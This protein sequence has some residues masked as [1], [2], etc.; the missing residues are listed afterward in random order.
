VAL[1]ESGVVNLPFE[2]NM[3]DLQEY[4]DVTPRLP[5]HLPWAAL[6]APGIV[7]QKENYL[8]KTYAFRGFDLA[9][10][11]S[12]EL[13]SNAARLNNVLIRLG[14]GWS[15]FVEAQRFEHSQY[16]D[17]KWSNPVGWIIDQERRRSYEQ[18]G[19]HFDS[20]YFI[21]FAYKLPSQ[22]SKKIEAIFYDDP[23]RNANADYEDNFKDLKKFADTI[24][25]IVDIMK[26]VF[27]EIE[28]LDDDQTLSYLHSSISTN[29]HPV[30]SPEIPMYLD[31]L[32][33]DQALTT[34]DIVML[35]DYF[36]PTCTIN[37]FPTHSFPGI[38][39]DL[40]HMNIEYRWMT[41]W[42]CLSKGDAENIMRKIQRNWWKKRKSLITLLKEEATKEES[43]LM[44]NDAVNKATDADAALQISGTNKIGF[45][46]MTS[47]ISTWSRS[48]DAAKRNMNLLRQVVSSNGFAVKNET[49]NSAQAWFGSLPGNVRPNPRRYLIK[50]M[51]LAHILPVSSIWAGNYK[52]EFLND[53]SGVDAPH[54]ICSTTGDTPFYLNLNDKDVGNTMI[55]G[56][57]GSGKSTLLCMLELQWLKYPGAQVI[58]FDKDRSARSAT[59]AVGGNFYE[60]G[61]E[62]MPMAFQPLSDIDDK[63]ERIWAAQLILDMLAVQNVQESPSIKKEID[64][65][66]S[67]LVG[68]QRNLR[69]MSVFCH[70]VQSREIREALR[71]YTLDGN[72]G[73]LF[74]SERDDLK[75]GFWQMIEMGHVMKMG[76][77]AVVPTL[78]YLFHRVE[79]RLDGRATLCVLDEAWL[80]L[81]HPVFMP[82]LQTWFKTWRKKNVFI[83]FATQ[84]V[85]DASKSPIMSTILMA[86]PTKIYLPDDE[87]QSPAMRESYR[88]F[89][90][91]DKE[92]GLLTTAEKKK[93]YY[94][95]SA[96][97]RRLFNLNMGPVA[98]TF[99]GMSR[100]KDHKFMDQMIHN[101]SPDQYAVE[102][103]KYRGLDDEAVRL[104]QFK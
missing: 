77:E 11:S 52:N 74:D 9:T 18:E 21:T 10:S 83:V 14:T 54:I 1:S 64:S 8:Q 37:Q 93:D 3:F 69:T 59:L 32:L 101:V 23:Y 97:G 43:A 72:F 39:D 45:G 78:N 102:L 48:L 42:E 19:S 98:L 17:I 85:A 57:V 33:P 87:A 91:S 35:D 60:P 99:A 88:F 65:A 47:T 86:C 44:D 6:I 46:Y 2:V 36:I 29:H 94:F 66:L 70:L 7:L 30:T 58:I 13:M 51:N 31:A 26:G 81:S 55:I 89:A 73:Q 53:I 79:Q 15:L 4:R 61:N 95:Q 49:I 38:L 90:L 103:L 67:S 41:R 25:E 84:E 104:S 96:R 68:N 63:G 82:K 34:G 50:T 62:S 71:P 75:L 5:D 56:P 20:N 24:N 40:N 28:E 80:F 100:D 12:S 92:I 16:P 76:P 27:A 22:S